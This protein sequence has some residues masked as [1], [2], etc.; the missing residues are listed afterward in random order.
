ML[1][2]LQRYLK[3]TPADLATASPENWQL[4]VFRIMVLSGLL[5]VLVICL[6]SSWQAWQIGAYHIIAITSTFY[7]ALLLLLR[8]SKASLGFSAVGFLILVVSAGLSILLLNPNFEMAKLGIVFLYALPTIA[9]MFFPLRV[10]VGLMLLNFI[11]FAFLLNNQPLPSLFNFSIT[12]PATHA[13]LHGLIFL[14]F[15]L[16]LPLAAAR[17]IRTIQ[18]HSTDLQQAHKQLSQ[19][20]DFYAELFENNGDATVLCASNG[21]IIKANTKACQ[22]LGIAADSHVYLSQVLLPEQDVPG[23]AFWLAQDLP[24]IARNQPGR[25]LQLKHMVRTRQHHH[26]LQLHD[27]TLLVQL[28]LKLDQQHQ[29]QHV[30][31]LY[32][33]LTCLPKAAFFRQQA[34]ERLQD[35]PAWQF[36]MC[37]IIR[38]CH[39]KTLNQQFGYEFGSQVLQQFASQLRQSLRP[40]AILGRLRGVKFALLLPSQPEQLSPA[41]QAQA[42]HRQLPEL[43]MIGTQQV[44]LRY[45]LG[46]CLSEGK[47]DAAT[48]LEQCEIALEQADNNV[49]MV[50]YAPE[51]AAELHQTYSL[52]NALQ[53]AIRQRQLQLFLQPKVNGQGQIKAFEA[54]CRWQH[55]GQWIAPD[56]FIDLA[57]KHGCIKAL[58]QLVL[59]MTIAILAQWQQRHWFYPIAINLAGPE[60][61]DDSFFAYLLAQSAHYPWL[62]KRLQLEITETHFATQQQGLHTRLRALSQYGFSIAIDDF[63]TGHASLSQLVDMPADT[64]KIDR[65]FVAAIP[66]HRQQIKVLHTTLQLARALNLTTVAEGVENDIQRKFLAKLGFP[67]LQGYLFGRPAPEEHW[68]AQLEQ[69]HPQLP[70]VTRLTAVESDVVG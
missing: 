69:Q 45:Q 50:Q 32:D 19:S 13:Y 70:E 38:L 62:T 29:H 37:L 63:G 56:L 10:M 20:H 7:L 31:Q 44:Q 64:L 25:H 3:L 4:S 14:F 66:H 21:R 28:K 52:A 8:R 53:E 51:Q 26:V 17:I 5:L 34:D 46:Y 9:L 60:L 35:Q 54:L 15:N 48:L 36:R 30:W 16:C 58:S 1:R 22:W 67:L 11:P 61:L 49:S 27:V 39:V 18:R 65:R 42:I 40:D 24:C 2:A 23:S 57:L 6:H 59:D 68:H 55:D 33:R 47:A 12:L 43:L 41:Q